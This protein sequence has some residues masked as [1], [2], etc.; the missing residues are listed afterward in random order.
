MRLLA[1]HTFALAAY[2]ALD[3]P[4]ILDLAF[5]KNVLAV[6][7]R[8]IL[9]AVHF[10]V[11]FYLDIAYLFEL[12][13]S[14]ESTGVI[15]IDGLLALAIGAVEN[16]LSEAIPES[17]DVLRDAQPAEGAV[18]VDEPVR[19]AHCVC[20]DIA[21]SF[22]SIGKLQHPVLHSLKCRNVGYYLD[23]PGLEDNLVL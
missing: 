1:F 17:A 11:S 7:A 5:Q 4:V 2:F 3:L 12:F 23:V 6:V 15:H 18:A 14:E 19:I 20:A 22:L 10:D 9:T 13:L 21:L 8:F 16:F